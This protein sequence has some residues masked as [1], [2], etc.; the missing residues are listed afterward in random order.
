MVRLTKRQFVGAAVGAIAGTAVAS[1]TH[2]NREVH[3]VEMLKKSPVSDDQQV[4][5]PP[6][7]QIAVGD[8]VAFTAT[9]R[10]HNSQ[11]NPDLL[12]EGAEP[13]KGKIGKDVEV[14]F[15]VPGVYGY[16]CVPIGPPEWWV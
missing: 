8:A 12:P 14:S 9:D 13:W 1:R 4:F 7:L 3:I 11:S 10:G 2:A 15:T 5:H 6:V 16:H